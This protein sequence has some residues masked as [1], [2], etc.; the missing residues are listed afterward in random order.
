MTDIFRA[1]CQN[2]MSAF[3]RLST[4]EVLRWVVEQT[5]NCWY[6]PIRGQENPIGTKWE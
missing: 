6:L 1:D 4:K 5:T 3:K 2:G